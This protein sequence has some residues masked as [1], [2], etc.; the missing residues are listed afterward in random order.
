[1]VAGEGEV[2]QSR[3]RRYSDPVEGQERLDPPA[4]VGRR[5]RRDGRTQDR[6]GVIGLDL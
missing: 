2:Q 4:F 3:G 6:R 5:K 1:M